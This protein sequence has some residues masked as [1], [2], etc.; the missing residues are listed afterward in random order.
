MIIF[1]IGIDKCGSTS[2]FNILSKQEWSKDLGGKDTNLLLTDKN[3][4]RE[5]TS[6]INKLKTL[7]KGSIFIEYSHDYWLSNAV[8]EIIKN[9]FQD[10]YVICSIRDPIHRAVSALK[11]YK[12]IG[13]KGSE[14]EILNNCPDIINNSFYE[15]LEQFL[16][17]S[18]KLDDC[19][20]CIIN[21]DSEITLIEQL[22]TCFLKFG[23]NQP[24]KNVDYETFSAK[25]SKYPFITNLVRLVSRNVKHVFPVKVYQFLK[26]K[27][28]KQ[29]F[30]FTQFEEDFDLQWREH[31]SN[32]YGIKML[33]EY[34]SILDIKDK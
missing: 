28:Y 30:L 16:K 11:H 2:I 29:N 27:F 32:L 31:I 12:K 14:K 1:Y 9:E 19:K 22:R 21:I 26:N 25:N 13:E 23:I 3:D 6:N 18:G 4:S 10:A 24:L 34:N 20:F 5:I 17:T 15:K 33:S 8:A 7:S